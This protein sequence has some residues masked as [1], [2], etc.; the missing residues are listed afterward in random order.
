MEKQ[1]RDLNTPP[2]ENPELLQR[3]N[4][5]ASEEE[6]DLSGSELKDQDMELVAKELKVNTVRIE[7][8][9]QAQLILSLKHRQ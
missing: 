3:I 4:E 2:Y 5:N 8:M 1:I 9:M 7:S 6:F